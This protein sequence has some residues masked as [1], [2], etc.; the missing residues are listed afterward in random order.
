M[1]IRAAMSIASLVWF[2]VLLFLLIPMIFGGKGDPSTTPTSTLTLTTQTPAA[3]ANT[4]TIPIISATIA[5]TDNSGASSGSSS[6]EPGATAEATPLPGSSDAS[7]EEYVYSPSTGAY[8]HAREDCSSIPTGV[9]T[10]RMTVAA[11]ANRG[12]TACPVCYEG[13]LYYT[14]AN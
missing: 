1:P 13:T 6:L 3:T 5:P 10:T 4:G 2:L 11:A 8:Y 14:T 12:Q 7:A 9:T